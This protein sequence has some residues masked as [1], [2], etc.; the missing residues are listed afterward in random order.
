MKAMIKKLFFDSLERR[1]KYYAQV[2]RGVDRL[3]PICG[4]RGRFAPF[5]LYA[6]RPDAE[7]GGCK[8]LERHRLL[9]LCLTQQ[10]PLDGR[11]RLLHFAP[12][13]TVTKYVKPLVERYETADLFR[14]DV[15]HN[16][17]IEAIDAPDGSFDA[18]ICNHVL[19]HVD[20]DAALAECHRIL[21]PGGIGIFMVPICE[22]LDSTYEN[23]AADTDE[24]RWAHFHQ[25]DHVRIFGR[26]VRDRFVAAG[27]RLEEFVA[28]GALAARHGLTLGERVFLA[29]A[30]GDAH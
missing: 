11:A 2:P 5:G 13:E 1:G 17:N 9:Y 21:A 10:R 20:C 7:C 28:D 6:V 12:E 27:F 8:S 4:Y 3:C 15:D 29:Y 14:K 19:E 24:Q 25:T 18:L 22:G 30:R 16:W 26:D 23:D